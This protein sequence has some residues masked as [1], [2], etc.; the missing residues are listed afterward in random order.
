MSTTLDENTIQVTEVQHFPRPDSPQPNGLQPDGLTDEDDVEN[1]MS[2]TLDE[3]AIPLMEVQHSLRTDSPQP[4]GLQP[5]GLTDENDIANKISNTSRWLQVA[6]LLF[7][8][9]FAAALTLLLASAILGGNSDISS[10]SGVIGGQMKQWEAKLVDFFWSFGLSQIVSWL[11]DYFLFGLARVYLIN[12]NDKSGK[13]QSLASLAAASATDSGSYNPMKIYALRP[14]NKPM[15]I[16]VALV[17]LSG[18][19][20]GMFS[21]I[22]AYEAYSKESHAPFEASLRSFMVNPNIYGASPMQLD[23]DA[24]FPSASQKRI[25]TSNA[26]GML[27]GLV[28][29][30]ATSQLEADGSYIGVNATQSS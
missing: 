11:L 17:L 30:N 3:N 18:V 29:Q 21:N 6:I 22:I 12:Q 5:D 14:K 8:I 24:L 9:F 20:F 4:N 7:M 13:P 25:F 16:F 28:Y 26:F 1:T 10:D 2:A 27:V 19:S 15:C 23:Q